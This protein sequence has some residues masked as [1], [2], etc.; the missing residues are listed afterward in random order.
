[1]TFRVVV[2]G[3]GARGK[4]WG[5]VLDRLGSEAA[6]AAAVDPNQAHAQALATPRGAPAFGDL[7]E[8]LETVAADAVLVATPPA[9]H[10]AVIER[11]LRHGLPILA[12]K[13]LADD[14]ADAVALVRQAEEAGVPLSLSVQFR[15]LPV[16]RRL[17]ELLAAQ[18]YGRPG[19][20]LFTYLRNRDPYAPHLN[21]GT[22][23]PV[24]ARHPMLVDQ[25]IH[26]YDLIR[27]CYQAEPVWLQATTWNP[28]WSQYAHDS[29]VATFMELTNGVRLQYLGT[30]TGGWNQMQ[31]EWRTDCERG[32][33]T[34]RELFGDLCVA[35]VDDPELTPVPLEPFDAFYDD[36][37]ALLR[38]F[39]V[40]LRQGRPV[41]CDG[42]DHLQTLA[43]VFAAIESA[44][45]GCR[46]DLEDFRRRHGLTE[47]VP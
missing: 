38:A 17:R 31:F 36:S 34:Q 44:E 24:S 9:T 22:R 11:V 7:E 16:S 25:T 40:S 15:Y 2:V 10:R 47:L 37:A 8:A 3:C 12:E 35:A 39:A 30:W 4:M 20:A 14:L 23:Y 32:I 45:T 18:P 6:L 29:N 46:V 42:R 21:W 1:M 33:V 28:S 19:F 5:E 43:M 41:P 13:P 26:H 27:F